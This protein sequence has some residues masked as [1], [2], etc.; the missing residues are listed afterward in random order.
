[1]TDD[2]SV[3]S[4]E[5]QW[6]DQRVVENFDEDFEPRSPE[7]LRR[8]DAFSRRVF[9]VGRAVPSASIRP[10]IRSGAFRRRP[11]RRSRRRARRTPRLRSVRSPSGRSADIPDP[12]PPPSRSSSQEGSRA[13]GDKSYEKLHVTAHKARHPLLGDG[14]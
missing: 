2:E 5:S 10:K 13:N 4:F 7:E 11:F 6:H 8:L 3:G 1:M 12:A 9:K 14:Y